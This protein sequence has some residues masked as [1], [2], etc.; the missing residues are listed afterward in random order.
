[1]LDKPASLWYTDLH[2]LPIVSDFVSR[3][4][5][6][7]PLKWQASNISY[8]IIN[9]NY[10]LVSSLAVDIWHQMQLW[11]EYDHTAPGDINIGWTH[12]GGDA[13]LNTRTKRP[14]LLD[15]TDWI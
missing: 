8:D 12:I 7:R 3:D 1:M 11:Y 4:S 13:R 6:N 10:R 14:G 5:Q 9:L 2:G 15:L